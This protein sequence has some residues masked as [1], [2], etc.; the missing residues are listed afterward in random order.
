MSSSW[1]IRP[2]R[3]LD[4]YRACVELQ[5]ETWG[6]G[7]SERVSL[8]ILKVSQRLGGVAAGAWNEEGRLGGFVFGMTGLEEGT[9]VHWSDMLAVRPEA[10]DTG[11]G[12][13]LKT[14]QRRRVLEIGVRT[15]YWTFDP[16]ESKNAYVNF[17]KLGILAREYV[18][19]MYGQTDS[20]L[21]RGIGT[22]RFVALWL[23]DSPRVRRR[24][25][26]GEGSP[27]PEVLQ[28]VARALDVV[29]EGDD[30]APR[31][32]EL[33]AAETLVVPIPRDIQALKARSPERAAAWREETRRVLT[34][35]LARGYEAE[36]LIPDGE[37]SWYVLAK[38]EDER[39]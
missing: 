39:T 6:E 15:M 5:E 2:F 8:A 38:R 37:T 33:P 21:H 14:Y 4:D 26:E 10:R 18:P 7:F 13:R 23:L 35:L 11:L 1:E 31:G 36:E 3:T 25:E 30:P 20:P 28:G 16:L 17:S 19:D 29:L 24:L 12:T 34:E 22:D 9:P 27:G 32:V